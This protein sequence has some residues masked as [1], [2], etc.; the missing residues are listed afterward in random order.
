MKFKKEKILL[1][2]TILLYFMSTLKASKIR[3]LKENNLNES[4]NSLHNEI[5]IKTKTENE[6]KTNTNNKTKSKELKQNSFRNDNFDNSLKKPL[7]IDSISSLKSDPYNG[8]NNSQVFNRS[9]SSTFSTNS[10][11]SYASNISTNS[12]LSSISN[13]QNPVISSNV[14]S[15]S[16]V[17]SSRVSAIESVGVSDNY[18]KN[19]SIAVAV[20][21]ARAPFLPPGYTNLHNPKYVEK[22]GYYDTDKP[23]QRNEEINSMSS[24]IGSSYYQPFKPVPNVINVPLMTNIYPY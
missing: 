2:F 7:I 21:D 19:S 12:N 4:K 6:S 23:T 18:S 10:N 8:T 17:F 1:V 3:N 9:T 16:N 5:K 24:D 15:N 13:L 22:I 11:N 14:S 20:S